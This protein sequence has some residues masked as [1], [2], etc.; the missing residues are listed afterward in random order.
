MS[1]QP[2]W[3]SVDDE[4]T[5]LLS[6]LADDGTDASEREWAAFVSTLRVAA[7]YHDGL[8]MPNNIRPAL[9]VLVKPNRVGAFTN[10]ALR[11]G[12]IAYTGDYQISDDTQ[13]RNAGKPARVMRWIGGDR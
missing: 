8:L 7:K 6:V 1:A 4:T 11:Q 12:L 5:T 13:G 9:R 10:R 3:S 2:E